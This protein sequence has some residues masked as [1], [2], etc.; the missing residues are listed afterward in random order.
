MT[1]IN[2]N[3]SPYFDDYNE[4]K[5]FH[6]ILFRPGRAVQ[7]RELT[8]LQ[9][10]LQ[11]QIERFGSHVF[12]QGSQVLPGS[13][14]GVRYVNNHHFI[15][16]AIDDNYTTTDTQIQQY[17]LNKTLEND[18]GVKAT[19]IGYRLADSNGEVILYL[20]YIEGAGQQQTFLRGDSLQTVDSITISVV[21][22]DYATGTISS[23]IVEEGVYFFD[24]NFILVDKQTHFIIPQNVENQY[25]WL[26]A[27]TA[28]VGLRITQSIVTFEEDESLLDNALG[29]PNYSAPGADR[30]RISADLE[31]LNDLNAQEADFIQLLKVIDG[32]VQARVVKTEYSVLEDTLARRTFDESGDYS[33]RPFQIQVKDFLRDATNNGAHSEKEFYFLTQDDALTASKQIFNVD[34]DDGRAYLDYTRSAWLPGKDYEDFINLCENKLSIKIDPG[35]AYVKGYEI[36]KLATTIVDFDKSRTISSR[37]NKSISTPLGTFFYVTNM[38]GSVKPYDTVNLYADIVEVID[39]TPPNDKIGTAKVLSLDFFTG[40]SGS[41]DGTYRLFLFDIRIDDGK[42]L[43]QLKSMYSSSP[44][45]TCNCSLENFRLSGSVSKSTNANEIIGV[46]TSWKNDENERLRV[47]DYIQVSNG[48]TAKKYRVTN[49]PENDNVLLVDPDPLSDGHSWQDGSTINYIYSIANSNSD[50]VGLLY[51]LPDE[52]VYSISDVSYTKTIV[53]ENLTPIADE[54]LINNYNFDTF[55]TKNYS[56][57]NLATGDWLEVVPYVAGNPIAGRAEVDV[58]NNQVNIY[59]NN[60]DTLDGATFNVYISVEDTTST[61]KTKNLNKGYFDLSGEYQNTGSP[62]KGFVV[63]G[64]KDVSEVSLNIPDVLRI[65]RVVESPDYSTTPSSNQT[66]PTGHKDVTSNYILDDGQRDHFYDI[67]SVSLRPGSP[68]PNGKIRVEFDYFTHTGNGNYFSVDS[69]PFKG[70]EPEMEYEEIPDYVASD[71]TKYDLT[72]CIDFRSVVSSPGGIDTGF[73]ISPDLPNSS[74]TC[75]YEFYLARKDKLYLDKNGSFY[76]KQ[77]VPDVNPELPDDPDTGMV[78][79]ELDLLPYT[80]NKDSLSVSFRDNKRYT[81]R[82]IGKLEKRI[83]NLEYYTTLSLL[84]TDT[85]NLV[86]KD[87]LGNDKFKNGFLVDN[88]TTFSSCDLGSLD[89]KASVDVINQTTR[90]IIFQTV[91]T[92]SQDTL[93]NAQKTGDL[94]TL[95]YTETT[96]VEQKL[97]SKVVS[98]NPFEIPS[99]VGNIKLTPWSDEWRDVVNQEPLLVK[100]QSLWE[101]TQQS[102]GPAGT[103]IDY[104]STINNWTGVSISEP[105]PTG[106]IILQGAGHAV[107]EQLPLKQRKRA[108]KTGF[109]IVPE[110]YANAGQRVP[111][112]KKNWISDELRSTFTLTGQQITTE[113]TSSFVDRGWS[114]GTNLGSRVISTDMAEFIR[115]R[116]IQFSARGLLPNTQVFPFFDGIDVSED[117]KPDSGNY[118]DQ[119][120]SDGSGKVSGTFKIPNSEGKRFKTGDRI[121]RITT[122]SINQ[123]NPPPTSAGEATYTARGWIDTQQETILSTRLFE[124]SRNTVTSSTDISLLAGETFSAGRAC[125]QDPIAQ[126]FFIYDDGGCFLTSVDLFFYKKPTGDFQPDITLEIRSV[127]DTGLPTNRILPFGKVIKG[128]EEITTNHIDLESRQITITDSEGNLQD[129]VFDL[130]E[131][132]TEQMVATTFTFESP[133]YLAQDEQYCFVL[134]SDSKEYKVWVAQFGEDVTS[135]DAEDSFREFGEANTRIGTDETIQSLPYLQGTFFKSENGLT[136]TEDQTVDIK[137][138][139]NKAQFNISINGEVD[140]VNDE[141]PLRA[142]TL[143][144]FETKDGSS[145]VRVLHPNHG[146]TNQCMVVFTSSDDLTADS[147]NGIDPT[148]LLRA[149]GHNIVQTELDHYVIDLRDD[150]EANEATASGR[151]GGG[152]IVASENIRFEELMLLTTPLLPQG[153]DISWSIETITSKGVNDVSGNAYEKVDARNFYPNEKFLFDVPMQITSTLNAN[154]N[155]AY[156]NG[157]GEPSLKVRAILKS[158]NANLS[159]IVD[160]SRFSVF[161]VDN[162]IDNPTSSAVNSAFDD[163]QILTT[164]DAPAVGNLSNKIW[165]TNSSSELTGTVSANVDERALNG[166]GTKFLSEV[167]IGDVI[168]IGDGS[169]QKRV[170]TAVNDDD[171]L[172]VDVPFSL[173]ID[174]AT[175]HINPPNVKIKTADPDVARHLSLLDV[176]KYITIDGTLN[177]DITESD[178][179][180]VL[181]VDY[182]PNNTVLDSELSS[183]K[184]CEITLDHKN[185]TDPG[186]ENENN[187]TI[188]QKDRFVDEIAPSGGSCSAKYVCKKLVVSRPSNSLKVLF[189]ANRHSSCELELYYKLEPVNSDKNIDDINWVKADFNLD[190]NGTLQD[191]TPNANEFEGEYSAYEVTLNGLPSFVGA[192]T[193]IVMRGGNP[194]RVPKVKNFR[195]IILDE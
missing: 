73:N 133:I 67:A 69:Y 188:V 4:N 122:S 124:I 141:L 26:E 135:R 1:K 163:L 92:L 113:F 50:K 126:S 55:S 178:L 183:A 104:A 65:T 106:G 166:S 13:K 77:G 156:P 103:T 62:G 8:Q 145:L 187:Y 140:F 147:L 46:G 190:V 6:R 134:I 170:V 21:D 91:A 114:T 127:S 117:C 60:A 89:F 157:T 120:V 182:T 66:L 165:F 121:F 93:S 173:S 9:S 90:P 31:Q 146:H 110:G 191:I 30:L 82:D 53:E 11:K 192:Q 102:F 152:N 131:D 47:G 171:V 125:P 5:K 193:K 118:G 10:S 14:E 130:G 132:P 195:M 148:V 43:A 185:L 16:I 48:L 57:I 52:F 84:E 96:L 74:F 45:F 100:D 108:K 81:M 97:A 137:F 151:V 172:V 128:V 112:G 180:K 181:K 39:G 36:E 18:L 44:T 142:L 35:K 2:L 51:N 109:V 42:D 99:Y 115:E 3:Q 144:P 139:L 179:V 64:G 155:G 49:N 176:G 58:N 28:I 54:L 63:S 162:R 12:E 186:F 7:A 169:D 105:T 143:D 70:N 111:V 80:A 23:V 136:W 61:P 94:Y 75:D 150:N 119:L 159:P 34:N 19:V 116:E 194:A 107:L 68:R 17:L 22:A 38:Y 83:S 88:F 87:A 138:K 56:I 164:D 32:V 154:V 20:N 149:S 129:G 174:E 79:Y 71:G 25:A 33:V 40:T 153:T 76:V 175:V 41:L 158:T 29:S 85:K 15:R 98:V 86:I 27:P 24:G 37:N 189:D 161:L 167:S 72:S 168:I 59:L 177:R 95:P 78:I 101:A 160:D 184:L 123:K